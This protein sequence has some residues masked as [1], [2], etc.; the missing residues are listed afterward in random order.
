M[1]RPHR[2]Q[3]AWSGKAWRDALLLAVNEPHEKG[4]KKLRALAEK[5]VELGLAGDIAAMREIGDRLDGKPAQSLTVDATVTHDLSSLSDAQLA[6]II[7]GAADGGGGSD[8]PKNDK[9]GLH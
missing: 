8:A 9:A 3:G 5:A 6:A 4:K 1:A 2:P 7:A